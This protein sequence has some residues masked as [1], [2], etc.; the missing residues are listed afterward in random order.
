MRKDC[1]LTREYLQDTLTEKSKLL[2]LVSNMLP[3]VHKGWEIMHTFL[4]LHKDT[5]TIHW[6]ETKSDKL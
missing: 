1:L 5:G 3:F 2:N 4:L 6:K